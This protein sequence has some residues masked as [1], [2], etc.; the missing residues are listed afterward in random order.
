MNTMD[1]HQ[2][3]NSLL[4][5]IKTLNEVQDEKDFR[6][7]MRRSE[8]KLMSLSI[9]D[10][11]ESNR[12]PVMRSC[13]ESDGTTDKRA[14]TAGG[15]LSTLPL[16]MQTTASPQ[17]LTVDISSCVLSDGFYCYPLEENPF[18]F[19]SVDNGLGI[20]V[21]S[22]YDKESAPK[23]ERAFNN[24]KVDRELRKQGNN[25][26]PSLVSKTAPEVLPRKKPSKTGADKIKSKN[27][28][29]DKTGA[30]GKD[31]DENKLSV[32]LE[33][34]KSSKEVLDPSR[35]MYEA[36]ILFHD[37]KAYE[38]AITCYT[39]ATVNKTPLGTLVDRY[40]LPE[41]SVYLRKVERLSNFQRTSF[42]SKRTAL[43]D[44]FIFEEEE[45]QRLRARSAFSQLFRL[46]LLIDD[47]AIFNIAA[48][49]TALCGSFGACTAAQEHH[50]LLVFAHSL[51]K[52]F[53]KKC[54]DEISLLKQVSRGRGGAIAEAHLNIL[55]ELFVLYP[56]NQEVVEWM[57]IRYAERC[58]FQKSQYYY[59]RLRD[60]KAPPVDKQEMLLLW[61]VPAN[62]QTDEQKAL[63]RAAYYN[64]HK[65]EQRVITSQDPPDAEVRQSRKDHSWFG[66][67]HKDTTIVLY[68]PPLQGWNT[69]QEG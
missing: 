53:A 57:G 15:N 26:M 9:R 24:A 62:Q 67:T 52:E 46:Q 36:A 29:R 47:P 30:D 69:E 42:F 12:V 28:K 23:L 31:E 2:H 68:Q 14:N 18:K 5:E 21:R 63:A 43:R 59:R 51:I 4:K 13:I 11:V 17:R 64:T 6:A 22:E 58:D 45:R 61:Q 55:H 35:P 1:D 40:D 25:T 49:H 38:R 37:M 3:R 66:G 10:I 48:A 41:D 56:A 54:V 50:D 32:A 65:L 33:F 34:M 7:I 44:K 39:A 8:N 60:L 20:V 27:K 16:I 19:D